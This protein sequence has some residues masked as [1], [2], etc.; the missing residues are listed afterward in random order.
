MGD[1]SWTTKSVFLYND[2][3]LPTKY[4]AEVE[5]SP[6]MMN[7]SPNTDALDSMINPPPNT[8]ALDPRRF[9]CLTER[10][11]PNTKPP[12]NAGREVFR[13]HSIAILSVLIK[14]LSTESALADAS[15]T[16]GTKAAFESPKLETDEFR[17]T[18]SIQIDLQCNLLIY[19]ASHFF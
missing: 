3:A 5:E 4:T 19:K 7:P 17:I 8:D 9:R 1:G 11:L 15:S 16:T 6:L 10:E 12:S 14:G 2:N 13:R 18:T